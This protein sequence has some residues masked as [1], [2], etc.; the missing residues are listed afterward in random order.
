[1]AKTRSIRKTLGGRSRFITDLI[2]EDALHTALVRATISRGLL[3]SITLPDFDPAHAGYISAGD[4]DSDL[5]LNL[6]G[7]P[8]PLLSDGGIDYRGQ[9]LGILW[10]DDQ[11]LL[12]SL[13]SQVQIEYEQIAQGVY[14]LEVSEADVRETPNPDVKVQ[15]FEWGTQVKSTGTKSRAAANPPAGEAD[16]ATDSSEVQGEI[17]VEH[18]FD[19]ASQFHAVQESLTALASYDDSVL[20][21]RTPAVWPHHLAENIARLLGLGS[22]DVEVETTI[23]GMYHDRLLVDTLVIGC[24]AALVTFR[25]KRPAVVQYEYRDEAIF[26][27]KQAPMRVFSRM[28]VRADTGILANEMTICLN[29]GAWPA[30]TSEIANQLIGSAVRTYPAASGCVEVRFYRTNLVP[31]SLFHGFL[32]GQVQTC[33]EIQVNRAARLLKLDPIE[34]RAGLIGS[35]PGLAAGFGVSD[36]WAAPAPAGATS[37]GKARRGARAAADA[38]KF[39]AASSGSAANAQWPAASPT[40]LPDN[41]DLSSAEP[42]QLS[43]VALLPAVGAAADFSRRYAAFEVLRSRRNE[44]RGAP[45]ARDFQ[46]LRGMGFALGFQPNQFSLPT[47][48]AIK[49]QVEID[50]DANGQVHLSGSA[51]PGSSALKSHFRDLLKEIFEVPNDQ[52]TIAT[53][54]SLRVPD[55]G[56]MTLSRSLTITRS[57]LIAAAKKLAKARATEPLPLHISQTWRPKKLRG[58]AAWQYP[59]FPT[60]MPTWGAA[61]VEVRIDPATYQPSVRKIWMKVMAGDVLFPAQARAYLE[62]T[63]IQAV[64]W[65]VHQSWELDGGLLIP[66]IRSGFGQNGD[67]LGPEI[68]LEFLD[69]AGLPFKQGGSGYGA[70][71]GAAGGPGAGPSGE[72]PLGIGEIAQA[73]IPAAVVSALGQAAG[74]YFHKIPIGPEDVHKLLEGHGNEG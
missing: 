69:S 55:A 71:S 43:R 31:L 68:D 53:V 27:T 42:E 35:W 48:R 74:A 24:L 57:L 40:G 18:C 25:T 8:L 19:L 61:A 64:N 12:A 16:A 56:P 65:C 36:D 72:E 1:M 67:V 73:V 70:G 59:Q 11:A 51:A 32:S 33:L 39:A 2:P 10:A 15:Q 13:V 9:I 52:I 30:F 37:A 21:I 6:M 46:E 7:D 5:V 54:S 45:E 66:R 22:D 62:G 34:F 23:P 58:G 3:R 20:T 38:A 60:G 29:M 44:N 26:A 14:E 17:T 63:I 41:F 49:P 4:F 47:E 50:L 28:T